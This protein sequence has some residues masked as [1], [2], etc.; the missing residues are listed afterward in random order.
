MM[1]KRI[2]RDSAFIRHC[3]VDSWQEKTHCGVRKAHIPGCAY[4]SH[5]GGNLGASRP[6]STPRIFLNQRSPTKSIWEVNLAQQIYS[7]QHPR[8]GYACT[9]SDLGEQ[10]AVDGTLASGTKSGFHFEIQCPKRGAQKS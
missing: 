10:S 9:L 7:A 2:V 5:F 4:S 6:L 1:P 3:D 8:A